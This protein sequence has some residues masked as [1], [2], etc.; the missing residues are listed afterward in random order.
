[1]NIT[2]PERS[3]LIRSSAYTWSWR[4]ESVDGY[5][6]LSNLYCNNLEDKTPAQGALMTQELCQ[7]IARFQDSYDAALEDPE[8]YPAHVLQAV[9]EAVPP[10]QQC[11][12]LEQLIRAW[13]SAQPAASQPRDALLAAALERLDSGA[14]ALEQFLPPVEA[15]QLQ[16]RQQVQCRCGQDMTLAANAMTCYTLAQSGALP[17]PPGDGSLAQTAIG[18]C[19]EDLLCSIRW[20]VQKGYL[21]EE[22][23]AQRRCALLK[24]FR[25]TLLLAGSAALLTVPGLGVLGS[26]GVCGGLLAALSRVIT[27]KFSIDRRML[28]AESD[29]LPPVSLELPHWTAPW[30]RKSPDRI[31]RTERGPDAN[32]EENQELPEE[33]LFQPF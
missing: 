24:A 23:A 12:I 30:S 33:Y 2:A 13:G 19:A 25:L 16:E 3:A 17:P 26:L 4:Q 31:S 20:D 7:W 15:A 10:E 27:E 22:E 5:M 29:H 9:L 14:D 32:Q 8:G 18:V 6:V 1:M 28:E 21:R 11:R